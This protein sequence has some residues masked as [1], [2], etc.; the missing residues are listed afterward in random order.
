MK[1]MTSIISNK[2]DHTKVL[3]T[4]AILI[5]AITTTNIIT[6]VITTNVIITKNFVITNFVIAKFV[7]TSRRPGNEEDA[8]YFHS[9]IVSTDLAV[10]DKGIFFRTEKIVFFS[11]DKQRFFHH[12]S[13]RER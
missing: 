9:L 2:C 1:L 10:I 7:V 13:E 4:N 6:N 11:I 12:H 5:N 8:D 3:I